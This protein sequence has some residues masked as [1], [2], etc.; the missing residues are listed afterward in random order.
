[1][2]RATVQSYYG[3][4]E[5]RWGYSR[6]LKG[7]RHF[8]F[9]PAGESVSV[10]EAQLLMEDVLGSRLALPAG[11]EVLDAGCGQG[12][13]AIRLADRFGYRIVGVDLLATLID[14]ARAN[15]AEHRLARQMRFITA[16][17]ADLP[18]AS[19]SLDG[20]YTME[21]LVH[22]GDYRAALDEFRRVLR[23]GGRLVL[24]EYTMPAWDDMSPKEARVGRQIVDGAALSSLPSFR[25]GSM[26]SI[27]RDR[28]FVDVSVEDVSE[29]ITPMLRW[30]AR[31]GAVPYL[32]ARVFGFQR[33]AVNAMAGV[34][35]YR[36]R[37]LWRYV[38]V[39]ARRPS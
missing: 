1:M 15:A 24:A 30:L 23:P 33:K 26:D 2:P 10:L 28:G 7:R 18:L 31:I 9:Y 19:Q 35:I 34:E 13:V 20:V 4:R 5:S 12:L 39:A 21:S 14:D 32:F 29:A 17:Y 22:A 11:S 27:L 6:L 3:S 38:I 36:N 16:D 25:T 8:G 37:H